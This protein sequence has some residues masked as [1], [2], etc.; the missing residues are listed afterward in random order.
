M[1]PEL[2]H[3]EERPAELVVAEGSPLIALPALTHTDLEFV[4]RPRVC[5]NLPVVDAFVVLDVAEDSPKEVVFFFEVQAP[6]VGRSMQHISPLLLLDGEELD[7]PEEG[8]DHDAYHF[9]L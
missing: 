5:H 3:S 6:S 1:V 8:G 2:A 7:I 4:L 9:S